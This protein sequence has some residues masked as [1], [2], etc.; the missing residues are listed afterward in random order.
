MNTREY[1]EMADRANRAA[2]AREYRQAR[3]DEAAR[4]AL[5]SRRP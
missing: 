3:E 5:L 4:L 2:A 1:L